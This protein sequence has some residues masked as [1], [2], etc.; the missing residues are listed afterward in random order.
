MATTK[1]PQIKARSLVELV[2]VTVSDTG[3]GIPP[4][5]MDRIFDPFFTTK[6]VGQ[7][8]GLGLSVSLGIVQEHGG[9]ITVESRVKPPG[10]DGNPGGSTFGMWLPVKEKPVW[11]TGAQRV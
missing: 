8:T 3:A 9:R 4:D 11:Q 2:Q 1:E 10:L 7:G 5:V 6:P